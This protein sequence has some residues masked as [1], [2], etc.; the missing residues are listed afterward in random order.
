MKT[1]PVKT[2][3]SGGVLA[4][5]A[6]ILFSLMV[7]AGTIPGE[8]A[9]AA[10]GRQYAV[11]HIEAPPVE[12]PYLHMLLPPG[13]IKV[14][15]LDLGVTASPSSGE[16][17]DPWSVRPQFSE[18]TITKEFDK[19]SPKLAFYCAAGQHFGTVSI[20]LLPATATPESEMPYYEIILMD[21]VIT[22]VM[23]CMVY[24]QE[25]QDYAHMEE[26]SFKYRQITWSDVYSA[27]ERTWDL[28]TNQPL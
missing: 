7:G 28:L 15:D 16:P 4:L 22:K 5:V 13:G 1:K 21:V 3:V 20:R 26:V 27:E 8:P 10:E 18:I 2:I 9:P 17:N 6:L 23:D 14:I 25:F 24:R 11:M 19:A 12:G